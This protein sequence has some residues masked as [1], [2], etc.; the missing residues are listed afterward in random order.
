MAGQSAAVTVTE[1]PAAT[2]NPI[3]DY[4]YD[5]WRDRR[6]DRSMPS[7][8]EIVPSELKKYLGWL[9]FVEAMPEYHDFRFR[10]VGTRVAEYFLSDATGLT[11]KEAYGAAKAGRVATD[12][13]LWIFRK[14]CLA[15]V[16]MRVTSGGG[17][18]RGHFFPDYDALYLPLSEN[19]ATANMVMCSFT[20]NYQAF[21]QTRNELVMTRR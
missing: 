21:L 11:V 10:L 1:N 17:E 13:V 16:P 8:G 3:L 9:C 7:R 4:F 14:T 15:R 2:D 5:Y 12:A 19:D 18:W 20:F 6:G